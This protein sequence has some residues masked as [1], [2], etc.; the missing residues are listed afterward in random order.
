MTRLLVLRLIRDAQLNMPPVLGI[1]NA[2]IRA[3]TLLYARP[4]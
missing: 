1:W 3:D 2:E 4:Q